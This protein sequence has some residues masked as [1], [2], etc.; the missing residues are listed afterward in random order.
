MRWGRAGGGRGAFRTSAVRALAAAPLALPLLAAGGS[1][2]IAVFT[3]DAVS[4]GLS[5]YVRTLTGAHDAGVEL[6]IGDRRSTFHSDVVRLK[7][8]LRAGDRWLLD[9]HSRIQMTVSSADGEAGGVVSGFGVSAVPGRS[10]DLETT[11]VKGERLRAWHDADRLALTVYSDA[12]DVTVGRQAVTWGLSLLFPTADLWTGFSPFELDAVEKPGT[13]ALRIL[14]YPASGV[15]LD[16]VV[17]DGGAGS[18]VS[19]GLR[20]SW[21]VAAADIYGAVGHLWNQAVV[22]GGVAWPLDSWTLRAEALSARDLGEE[23]R[24]FD[25]RVTVGID[26]LGSRTALS[27][28]YH[29]NGIGA[30]EP[31]EY[32]DRLGGESFS[33]GESYFLGRHFLGGLASRTLDEESRIR[34]AAS[35]LVNLGD[36]SAVLLPS[37][38][39][40]VGTSVRFAV[41]GLLGLGAEP[42][43]AERVP[44]LES[45][46]GTY[47][48]LGYA[49]ASVYF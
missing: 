5:G 9:V 12:A 3:T 34:L 15:E 48:T 21:S 39:W 19:M 8:Q 10:V 23:D 44:A 16:A 1:A 46:F 24:W 17:A 30:A 38:S 28:E 43:W 11:W 14:T 41:G 31:T 7:W 25:P 2:Q 27:A 29:Y 32:L 35:V 42:A 40:D 49:E 22:L 18:G 36:P 47:G 13:D 37:L 20:A 45:E 33:R 26:R 4:L 6:P